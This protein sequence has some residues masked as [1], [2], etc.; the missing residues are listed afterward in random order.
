MRVGRQTSQK[1]RERPFSSI[2]PVSS[3]T[4]TH[5]SGGERVGA[6]GVCGV[7]L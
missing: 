6:F 5:P 2:S 1:A 3:C 4:H 7:V